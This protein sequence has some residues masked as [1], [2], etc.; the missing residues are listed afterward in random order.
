MWRVA[1]SQLLEIS[2]RS[3]LSGFKSCQCSWQPSSL[4]QRQIQPDCIRILNGCLK[5]LSLSSSTPWLSWQSSVNE[6]QTQVLTKLLISMEIEAVGKFITLSYSLSSLPMRCPTWPFLTS[7]FCPINLLHSLLSSKSSQLNDARTVLS[8]CIFPYTVRFLKFDPQ[9][10]LCKNDTHAG[11]PWSRTQ[12]WFRF[13]AILFL[14]PN[15]NWGFLYNAKVPRPVCHS[16]F[17]PCPICS[18]W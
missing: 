16:T 5:W 11:V 10:D 3:V 12:L 15:P 17:N 1:Q 2:A 4:H 9:W 18:G 7:G 8:C 6:D 14:F 13:F